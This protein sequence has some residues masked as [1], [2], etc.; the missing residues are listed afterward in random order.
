VRVAAAVEEGAMSA[1]LPWFPVF[2][3]DWL[4][5][6]AISM[7]LPE[8]E[9]A[10]W[11]LLNLS[12]ANGNDEPSLPSDDAALGQM[13]RLGSR[14][15]KLGPLVRAQFVERDGKLYNERLSAV[16]RDQQEKHAM[17]VAK[18]SAGGRAK[19][20]LRRATSG[21]PGS[22]PSTPEELPQGMPIQNS[23]F[24][25]QKLNA[26]ELS[27][28]AVELARSA[29]GAIAERWGEQPNPLTPG[30]AS[31]AA[32]A[33][34]EEGVPATLARESI[35]R[36]CRA[37]KKDRPPSAINYFV[38]GILDDRDKAE[39]RAYQRANPDTPPPRRSPTRKTVGESNYD[40]LDAAFADLDAQEKAS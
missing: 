34:S 40:K 4:G 39:A 9:G 8:Q 22:A 3:A 27:A 1:E 5:S 36:Q 12:W 10:Y 2:V 21:A 35:Y 16:W 24:R 18:A 6:T 25:I 30:S 14:W 32:R 28:F 29:N 31:I 17:I 13:S 23:E 7:M 11:R 38:D 33:L 26:E 19:A 20:A 37:L 15:R